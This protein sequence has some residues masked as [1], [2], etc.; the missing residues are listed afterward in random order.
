MRLRAKVDRN[1]AEIVAALEKSGATVLHLHMVGRGCPDIAV[2]HNNRTYLM[3]I[4]SGRGMLTPD[5]LAFFESWRG[6]VVAVYSPEDA[7]RV[8]GAL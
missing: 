4:K 5:E 2:G 8:I 6:Q 1:Q 3:E 7:L